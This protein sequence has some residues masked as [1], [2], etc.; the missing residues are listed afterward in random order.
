MKKAYPESVD[1]GRG[2]VK[3]LKDIVNRHRI[4][5]LNQRERFLRYVRE[6]Q[7]ELT[8]LQKPPYAISNGEAVKLFLKGLDKEFL[9]AITLLLPAAA[10]DRRVEDPYDIEDIISAAN[11]ACANHLAAL[12]S[13]GA[14]EDD[15][16][17]ED[18]PT[19]PL[20]KQNTARPFSKI[21]PINSRSLP[22]E[23]DFNPEVQKSGTSTGQTS[24]G[25]NTSSTNKEKDPSVFKKSVDEE[26]AERIYR[27]SVV[28]DVAELISVSPAVRRSVLRRAR[29][30]KIQPKE[31]QAMIQVEG[32][33]G[34]HEESTVLEYFELE[35]LAQPGLEV[36][37]ESRDDLPEGAIVQRDVVEQFRQDRPPADREK[38]IIVAARRGEDLR[39]VYPKIN[40]SQEEV[41]CVLD[42]GS[43]IVSMDTNIAVGLDITWDPDV[44][45]HMQSANGNLNPTRGLARNVPFR[46]GDITIYLQVH[47]MDN[48][49]YEVL[50]GRPFDV[51]VES[52]VKNTKQG[53]QYIT[54]TDPNSSRR[55]Q[56][57][58][59]SRRDGV[60]IKRHGPEKLVPQEDLEKPSNEEQDHEGDP[61]EVNFWAASRN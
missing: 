59:Y 46:F 33:D 30:C 25:K 8:K 42:S 31:M 36:L 2:S 50:M 13:V 18:V 7:L 17:I 1:N 12:Y 37:M 6:F 26:I 61:A 32:I 41:E 10:E 40:N 57:G 21:V 45:I 27:G 19:K 52:E 49:P 4:I 58:T 34:T 5:P 24:S 51:L 47:V 20:A 15:S 43:Q 23:G 55:Q 35:E 28:L 38:R 60:K 56:I 54:L 29:N 16:D 44:V 39:V 14:D 11:K 22:K 53:D 48:V 3:R 9:R